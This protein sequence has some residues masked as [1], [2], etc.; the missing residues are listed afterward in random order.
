MYVPASK[1]EEQKMSNLYPS[2][3]LNEK[4]NNGPLLAMVV[5]LFATAFAGSNDRPFVDEEFVN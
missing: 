2:R 5:Q 3:F 1:H 4:R